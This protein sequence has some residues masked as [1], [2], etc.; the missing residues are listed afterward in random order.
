MTDPIA[1]AD[2]VVAAVEPGLQAPGVQLRDVVLVTGPWL[3]GTTSVRTALQ[4]R[5]PEHTFVEADALAAA[6]APTAVLFVVSAAAPVTESDGALLELAAHYT[7]LAIGVVTKI[8]AHQDWREVLDANRVALAER[9]TRFAQMPWVGVAAA[10]DLGAPILDDLVELLGDRLA[11]PDVQRRNRLRSW[12]AR[13]SAV[14]T[15]YE[16]DAAGEDRRARVTALHAHRDEILRDRRVA[17]SERT[18]AVRSQIQQARVQLAYFARNRC[19][20]VRAEWQEDVA[21]FNH[22]PWP[23]A[24]RRKLDEFESYVRRRADEVVTEVDEGITS[25]LRDMADEVDLPAPAEPT[26][27]PSGPEIP[28]PP[29]RSRRLENRLL[30]V[31]GAG[32]GVGVAAAAGRL[33]SGLSPTLTAAG[34]VAGALIALAVTVWMVG[35]RS[36]LQERAVLDRWVIEVAAALRSSLEELVATRVLAAES[37]LTAELTRRDEEAGG[38]AAD[39]IAEIDAELRE[40]AIARSRAVAVRDQRLPI[41]QAALD[42]VRTELY[43]ADGAA[44]DTDEADGT[45][46]Q[47]AV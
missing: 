26:A 9:S 46:P 2:A 38:V 41:L 43:Q 3:A 17:K 19:T 13:L 4:Q 39:Q 29:L 23:A 12:E 25:H 22:L 44:S 31:L 45:A 10:P 14:I 24:G 30:M 34:M 33:I 47:T 7:D 28:A 1:A 6:E 11:D 32:F 36:V 8:D 18:I 27:A 42:A 5:L 20:S 21:E 15:R 35:L 37:E 40:H 16:A